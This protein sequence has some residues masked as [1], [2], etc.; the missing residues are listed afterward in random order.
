MIDST[1]FMADIAAQAYAVGDVVPM[2]IKAG[3]GNVR[4]GYGKAILKQV[5]SGYLYSGA[6]A[7]EVVVQNSNLIDPIIN[8]PNVLTASTSLDTNSVGIQCGHDCDLEPNS[9]WTVYAKCISAGTNS[10]ATSIFAMIDIDYPSVGSVADPIKEQGIPT[11]LEGDYDVT[12]NLSGSSEKATWVSYSVDNF[13]P[14]YKY[15]LEKIGLYRTTGSAVV[16]GFV[17][18]ANAAAQQGLSRI[19][20][21][22]STTSAITHAVTYAEAL[23]KGPMDYKFLMF[24]TVASADPVHLVCDYVKRAQ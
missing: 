22:T 10:S 19:I 16:V 2:I 13:K 5:T 9:S 18:F 8:S 7:F 23:T 21:V 12:F 24:N 20:P 15:L 17:A 6:A 14:G 3:P 1:L 11:S 4:S